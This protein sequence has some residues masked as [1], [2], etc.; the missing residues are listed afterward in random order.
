MQPDP[1]FFGALCPATSLSG[2]S[3][4]LG[5]GRRKRRAGARTLST[6]RRSA[7]QPALVGPAPFALSSSPSSLSSPF[8]P[9]FLA[10]LPIGSRSRSARAFSSSRDHKSGSSAI[11]ETP[12]RGSG[13][14]AR[15]NGHVTARRRRTTRAAGRLPSPRAASSRRQA[16]HSVWPQRARAVPG[17]RRGARAPRL[18]GR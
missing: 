14:G 17:K 12:P 7:R 15:Q 18:K 5:N 10:G 2:P 13:E 11:S 1:A 6:I 9:L 3:P 4:L 8:S 16:V